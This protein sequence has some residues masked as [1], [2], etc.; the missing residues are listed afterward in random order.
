MIERTVPLSDH[1]YR[2][3]QEAFDWLHAADDLIASLL[4]RMTEKRAKNLRAAWSTVD[5]LV[6]KQPGEHT[7]IDWINRCVV[8]TRDDDKRK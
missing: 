3:L 8:V 5:R 6:V 4:E 2:E 7:L 1:E